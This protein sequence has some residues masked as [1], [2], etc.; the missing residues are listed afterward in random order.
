[1][2][3]SKKKSRL[4]EMQDHSEGN[5]GQALQSLGQ[6][7]SI[8][9]FTPTWRRRHSLLKFFSTCTRKK[10]VRSDENDECVR[11]ASLWLDTGSCL[12]SIFN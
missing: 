12:R 5:G 6:V 8:R 7:S 10:V 9:K 2:S 1:M 4:F 3:F 11:M